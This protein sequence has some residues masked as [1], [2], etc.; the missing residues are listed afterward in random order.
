MQ[1]SDVAIG[2]G[3]VL[4]VEGLPLFV[5]PGRYRRLLMQIEQVPDAVLRG[6]GFAA[7]CGGLTLLY[8]L[9][10]RVFRSL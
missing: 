5:S 7:M 9:K 8:A 3:F 6:A 1:L 10:E 4:I 2:L